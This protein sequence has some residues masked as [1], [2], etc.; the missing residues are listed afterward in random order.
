MYSFRHKKKGFDRHIAPVET[1]CHQISF[2]KSNTSSGFS[3]KDD[4]PPACLPGPIIQASGA[5]L[6]V[7][8]PGSYSGGT[9]ADSHRVPFTELS[10]ILHASRSLSREKASNSNYGH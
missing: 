3:G 9:V 6:P 5:C 10:S 2:Y 8:L 1:L 4:L 7:R